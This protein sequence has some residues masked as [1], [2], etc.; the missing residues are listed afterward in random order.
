[1]FSVSLEMAFCLLFKCNAC[2]KDVAL[3]YC[4]VKFCSLGTKF[5]GSP[6]EICVT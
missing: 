2:V 1:M 6:Y 4:F 5:R 3:M